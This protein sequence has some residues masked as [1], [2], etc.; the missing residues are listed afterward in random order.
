VQESLVF[1]TATKT[2]L[3]SVWSISRT[4]SCFDNSC[5]LGGRPGDYDYRLGFRAEEVC[6]VACG[7]VFVICACS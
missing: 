7:V 4:S 1:I 3:V 5:R 6:T 2:V